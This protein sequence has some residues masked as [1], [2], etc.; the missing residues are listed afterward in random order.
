MVYETRA[1]QVTYVKCIKS[2]KN[3]FAGYRIKRG[4]EGEKRRKLKE[5]TMSQWQCSWLRT[6][7][8]KAKMLMAYFIVPYTQEFRSRSRILRSY[9]TCFFKCVFC[10]RKFIKALRFDF[11]LRLCVLAS[12][13][14]CDTNFVANDADWMT[15][16]PSETCSDEENQTVD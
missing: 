15:P 5:K 3:F 16:A 13:M 4:G 7:R 12:P 2:K 11:P 8:N 14:C 10:D 6:R 1:S 9:L